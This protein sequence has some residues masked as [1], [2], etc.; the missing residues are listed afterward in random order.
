MTR[1]VITEEL[2]RTAFAL[3]EGG[4]I[5]LPYGS[6]LTP[7]ARQLLSE[8][9]IVVRYI[10]NQGRVFAGA[11][12]DQPLV[13]LNPL[14]GR[15]AA[16]EKRDPSTHKQNEADAELI[17]HLDAHTL[18]AKTHPRI[19]LR[20]KLDTLIAFTVLAQ[21][22]FDPEKR[23]PWLHPYLAELRSRM[24]TLLKSEVTGETLAPPG[25]AGIDAEQLQALSHYPLRYL[26]HDHIVP[27]ES[28]GRN[29]ARL[30]VLRALCREVEIA[31]V[32]AFTGPDGTMIRPDLLTA[33]NRL[34]SGLYV[35]MLLTVLAEKG[36]KV[37][38]ETIKF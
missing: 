13:R 25:L 10:D 1:A 14:T 35:L 8:R 17:T 37:E 12:P 36:K 16:Q 18:V 30:N 15:S 28:Q 2:L 38:L 9:H 34:S 6:E 24:G 5:H 27:E 29:V 26:G 22:D 7:A 19:V 32:Q 4:E 31:I 3:A 20:G 11:A 23:F 33:A 21:S